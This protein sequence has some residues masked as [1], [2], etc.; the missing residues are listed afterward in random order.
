MPTIVIRIPEGVFDTAARQKLGEN[1]TEVAKAAEQIGD[2]PHHAMSTWVIIEEI[3]AGNMFS[4]GRD[5]LQ[6]FIPASVFWYYPEGVFD[7]D[8]RAEAVRLIQDAIAAAAPADGRRVISAV[9][10]TQVDDGTWSAAGTMWRLADFA[11]AAGFKHLQHLV[12]E[13]QAA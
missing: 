1:V 2:E 11:R 9:A 5:P 6:A 7:Q 10:M 4:G 12:T 13:G 8:G 3:K